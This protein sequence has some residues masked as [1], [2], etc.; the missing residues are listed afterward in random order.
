MSVTIRKIAQ[1][2]GVSTGTVDRALHDRGRVN[3]EV[4]ARIKQIANELNYQPNTV[5]KSLSTR[6]RNLK[7][8]VILHIQ[9]SNSFFDDVIAGI[10]RGRDEIRDFG[11]SVTLYRSSNFDP[12]SQ[13]SMIDQAISDGANAIAIVPI[14]DERIKNR[15]NEL[16]AKDF[17]VLFLTNIIENTDYF[18]FVGCNYSLA[19][20]LT[21][22]LLNL[23]EPVEGRLLLFSPSFQMYGHTLRLQGLEEQLSSD[24]PHLHL[25][26]ALELTGDDIQDYQLTSKALESNPDVNLF[27]CPGAYSHGNLQAISDFGFLKKA[28]IICYDYSKK[29]DGMIRNRDIQAAITQ[30]PQIQGYTAIKSLFEYLTTE[31]KP[32]FKNN[33]VSMG[34]VLKENLPEIISLRTEYHQINY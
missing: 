32:E 13:L 6:K 23:L 8:A 4:A 1:L 3:P 21:A 9:T 30:C 34:I 29:I 14:N 19:G 27:V 26:D 17:P 33:Y 12:V 24:Y 7:I 11:I 16:Y 15:L 22:G 18:S 28:R 10:L 31:K 25:I 2:A 20:K 5:A